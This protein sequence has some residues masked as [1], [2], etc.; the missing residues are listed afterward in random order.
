MIVCWCYSLQNSS[1]L[2]LL[3]KNF[4]KTSYHG[5]VATHKHEQQCVRRTSHLSRETALL[6]T[7]I[8][9][10]LEHRDSVIKRWTRTSLLSMC[11]HWFD[12]PRLLTLVSH[13]N[14]LYFT[15]SYL[16]LGTDKINAF[17][18]LFIIYEK[19]L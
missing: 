11:L 18:L 17:S 4:W 15:S 5:K 10:Q 16:Y 7:V 3:P 2:L 6:W 12:F 8:T 1:I 14:C 13:F 9:Q 19:D